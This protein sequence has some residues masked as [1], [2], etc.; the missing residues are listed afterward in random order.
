MHSILLAFDLWRRK[1]HYK[2]TF[3]NYLYTFIQR[4]ISKGEKI[5][6]QLYD[7]ISSQS[8]SFYNHRTV[9]KNENQVWQNN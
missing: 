8:N 6:K 4:Y 7:I 1:K 2:T 9:R 3:S 5:H